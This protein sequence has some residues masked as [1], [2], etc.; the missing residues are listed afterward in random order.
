MPIAQKGNRPELQEVEQTSVRSELKSLSGETF[1]SIARPSYEISLHDVD[2]F[3][4][5][6]RVGQPGQ[7]RR[8]EAPH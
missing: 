2:D 6:G 3:A 1:I 7:N 5:A 8:H 4:R